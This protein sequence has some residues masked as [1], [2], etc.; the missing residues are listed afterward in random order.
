M[1][2]S[3]REKAMTLLPHQKA[4]VVRIRFARK[5]SLSYVGHLDLMRTFER[6]PTIVLGLV[7]FALFQC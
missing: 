4:N 3:E 1:N 7:N 2:Q 5:G 6:S